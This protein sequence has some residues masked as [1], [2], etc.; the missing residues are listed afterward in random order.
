MRVSVTEARKPSAARYYV[1]KL[2]SC[3]HCPELTA[4]ALKHLIVIVCM[5]AYV[6]VCVRACVCVCVCV[7]ACTPALLISVRTYINSTLILNFALHT[8]VRMYHFLRTSYSSTTPHP[9]CPHPRPP[10]PPPPPQGDGLKGY[11]ILLHNH[12]AS[13]NAS[14]ELMDYLKDRAAVEEA[15][16]KAL[17]RM[18]KTLLQVTEPAVG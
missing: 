16:V 2:F 6:C 4:K 8:Y 9:P 7:C 3:Y 12:K 10:P 15:Y 13:T 11:D 14:K 18:H 5:C 1:L 17:Q